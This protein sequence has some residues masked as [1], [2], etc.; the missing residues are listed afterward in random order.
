MDW[1]I[2]NNNHLYINGGAGTA[3]NGAYNSPVTRYTLDHLHAAV[4]WAN[5][6]SNQMVGNMY[7]RYAPCS[8]ARGLAIAPDGKM[9]FMG[10]LPNRSTYVVGTFP[11][12]GSNVTAFGKVQVGTVSSLSG[13]VRYDQKGNLYIGSGA[14]RPSPFAVPDLFLSDTGFK[15]GMGTVFKFKGTD[16]GAVLPTGAVN[17]A[18]VYNLPL[19]PFS[20]DRFGGCVCRSPRFEL[21]P[22]GRMFLPSAITCQVTVADDEGNIIHQFGKYGNL[23]SRGS[24]PGLPS[25]AVISG[26]EIP[27]AWPTSV[28]ASEDYI[29]IS[30]YVNYRIVR[31]KMVY[32]ADNYPGLTGRSTKSE[33]A[34]VWR[35][36][37]FTLSSSPVPFNN[38]TVI[39]LNLPA[40]ANITLSVLDAKGQ[41]V[42][43]IDKGNYAQGMHRFGWDGRNDK[44]LKVAAGLYIYRVVAGSKVLVSK[45]IITR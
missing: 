28:A 5:T 40:R 24:L 38:G 29:Y 14:H 35:T 25:Q 6:D 17:A 16:S 44:H 4:K 2:S 42:R 12:S 11:D 21:D 45:T 10:L 34:A 32:A 43:T 31:A 13:G 39:S 23:D 33:E 1:T 27:M 22:Y 3:M 7:A 18:K 26:T 41:L 15:W 9:A 30:D 20:A 19:S 36:P 8:G 37:L